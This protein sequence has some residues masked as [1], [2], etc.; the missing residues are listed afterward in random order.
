MQVIIRL[1]SVISI[2]F[3][4]EIK[5]LKTDG[6]VFENLSEWWKLEIGPSWENIWMTTAGSK[7]KNHSIFVELLP[8]CFLGI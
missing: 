6:S 8:F 4:L 1:T 3:T 7:L 2:L 5:Y